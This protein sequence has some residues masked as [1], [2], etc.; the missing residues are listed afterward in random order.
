MVLVDSSV[1]INLLRNRATPEVARLEELIGRE[2][3]AIGDLMLV[4]VLQGIP[5]D[6]DFDNARRLFARF[7]VVNIAGEAVALDAARNYRV[8]RAKGI[9]PRKTIDT[10]IATRCIMDGHALLF[11]DRDF[12][13]FVEHLGLVD[14]MGG[15]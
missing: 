15:A 13:S 2:Q 4:E 7:P 10:L 8:L 6:R 3:I 1:W 14:A 5:A 11:S 9:T 12:A